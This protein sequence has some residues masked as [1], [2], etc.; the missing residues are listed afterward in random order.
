MIEVLIV[1]HSPPPLPRT[2]GPPS[3][4]IRKIP[5]VA[6]IISNKP[7]PSIIQIDGHCEQIHYHLRGSSFSRVM[8]QV[9]SQLRRLKGKFSD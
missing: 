8:A 7:R 6:C 9:A 1:G 5:V 4:L 3:Y 2:P